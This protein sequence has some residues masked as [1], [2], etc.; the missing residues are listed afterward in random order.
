[1]R[2]PDAR[3]V[4]I[5]AFA[6]AAERGVT[7]RDE[8]RADLGF[9]ERLYAS[10]REAEFAAIGWP[11]ATLRAFLR[12]QFEAQGRHYRLAFPQAERLIVERGGAA[13]GRLCLAREHDEH[14]IVDIALLPEARGERLG[15]A[16]LRDVIEG[17]ARLE[18]DVALEVAIGNPARRLYA[19]LGFVAASDDGVRER[20]VRARGGALS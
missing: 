14:R 3:G 11:P 7:L 1:M 8:T 15:G 16:I 10:A 6:R 19:R 12:Q 17:A 9:L 18:A 4:R 13:I 5:A 20:M 2:I